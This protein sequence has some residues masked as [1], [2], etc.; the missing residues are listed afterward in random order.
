MLKPSLKT[1]PRAIKETENVSGRLL[2]RERALMR[3]E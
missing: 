1:D 2:A 3:P